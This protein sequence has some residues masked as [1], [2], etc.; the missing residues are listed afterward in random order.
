MNN[1]FANVVLAATLL[2]I[3]E[4]VHVVDAAGKTVIYNKA[5]EKIEGMS[6]KDVIGKHILKAYSGW[7]DDNSTLLTVL[8][9]GEPIHRSSQKYLNLAGKPIVTVNTTVPLYDGDRLMGALEVSSNVTDVSNLSEEVIKL[10]QQLIKP[11]RKAKQVKRYSF[12]MLI[13]EDPKY[14]QAVN[15][16]L[17][18]AQSSS[19]ILIYGETGTGKEL[20]AQSI[21]YESDRAKK[22]FIAINCAA[23]PETLLE[24]TLF[25]TTRGSFTGAVDRPG[26]FEQA[27]GG[28]LFLDELNSMSLN[29]QSKLLRVLQENYIRRIGG[30]KD[31]AVDVRIIAATNERPLKLLARGELRNDLY[32]RINVM[33]LEIPSLRERPRDIDLLIS[34]FLYELNNKLGKDVWYIDEEITP[35]LYRYDW[36]GNVRELLNFLESALNMVQDEHIIKREHLPQHWQEI[37]SSQE[38]AT[39]KTSQIES[40]AEAQIDLNLELALIEK[41]LIVERI[42]RHNGNITKIAAS[43]GISRQ[44]LQYKLKKYNLK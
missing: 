21:H 29:L 25:G 39:K 6:A 17:Q 5:M 26:L 36:K 14:L 35:H 33:M 4:G 37:I 13:G 30:L 44:N 8:K 41:Q 9:T 19:N 23:L 2:Q 7:Q 34:H 27:D 16:A 3:D 42:L 38:Y 32:Y 40:S 31:I 24:A 1:S 10:R 22:P 15:Q 18:A 11:R 20:F 28:T 43:L 12:D